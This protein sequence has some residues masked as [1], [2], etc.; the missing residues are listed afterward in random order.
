MSHETGTAIPEAGHIAAAEGDRGTVCVA[1]RDRGLREAIV[2]AL[3]RGHRSLA[4][5]LADT[6]ARLDRTGP[7][8]AAAIMRVRLQ[9]SLP[10]AALAASEHAAR[11][12]P[13]LHLLRAVAHLDLG[14]WLEAHLELS[15]AAAREDLGPAGLQLLAHL[16]H[17]EG[18]RRQARSLLN[19]LRGCGGEQ[20]A[21]ALLLCDAIETGQNLRAQDLADSLFQHAA[22]PE[23][24]AEIEAMLAI[25]GIS[26]GSFQATASPRQVSRLAAELALAPALI[27]TL[28]E[29]QRR[30]FDAPSAR[31]LSQALESAA[32]K[33]VEPAKARAA[34]VELTLM[35]DGPEVAATVLHAAIEDYRMSTTLRALQ[36]RLDRERANTRESQWAR[37]GERHVIATI[38]GEDA[39]RARRLGV[40]A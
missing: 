28:V 26:S 40:A 37:D 10:F 6:A 38:G 12:T 21:L 2:D 7:S 3:R 17:R 19:E 9:Q 33:M 20:R 18:D 32:G 30:Q 5:R 35:L 15:H 1:A 23:G 27:G 39:D 31:M 22:I 14:Q 29:A 16:E 4:R 13:E 11:L 8:L 24:R 34:I 36:E 25:L